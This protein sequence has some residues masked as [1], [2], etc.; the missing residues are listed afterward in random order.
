MNMQKPGGWFQLIKDLPIS[1]ILLLLPITVCGVFGNFIIPHDPTMM[2]P[3]MALH[4]PSWLSGEGWTY[5]MGT[6]F[7]GRDVFSRI[8]IG[9]RASLIVS[10][11]G[12][13]TAGII[14][15]ILGLSS[16]FFGGWWDTL[17]VM[18]IDIQR[19]I[20][21]LLFALL[22]CGPLGAGLTS[23]I[24]VVAIR[25]WTNYARVVRGETLSIKQ[26]EY[27]V[28]AKSLGGKP[29]RILRKHILPNVIDSAMIVATM[30]LGN[31]VMLEASLSFLGLG[32]QAPAVAWGKMIAE[33]RLY[34]Q[35]A[36][37]LPTFP[38]LALFITVL[39]ANMF[40]DW[41]RDKLDPKLRQV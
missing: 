14:G 26:R 8:I 38:G 17:V 36:W 39:G 41:L 1:A 27:V 4:P 28:M 29:R 34:M 18:V 11:I 5:L 23:V 10:F 21:G 16:A 15:V 6:D 35:S 33:S 32:V 12:V 20:P 24:I 7:L 37:W 30:Q 3:E 22:L 19:S 2:N 31:A 13:G 25:Y 9:A 40:G